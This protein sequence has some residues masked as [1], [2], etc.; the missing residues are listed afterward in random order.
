M[1]RWHIYHDPRDL[2]RHA[3]RAVL[4][5]AAEALSRRGR[6]DL[7]ISGGPALERLFGQFRDR[8]IGDA[9][10]HIWFTDERCLPDGHPEKFET[11]IRDMWL[12]HSRVPAE[13]IHGIGCSGAPEEAAGRYLESLQEVECFDLVLLAMGPD[14]Q[15]A[16]LFP[17]QGLAEFDEAPDVLAV[18]APQAP[19]ARITLSAGRLGATRQLVL[20]VSGEDK[21]RAVG[22]WRAG[23]GGLPVS[24]LRPGRG[25]DVFADEAAVP[26]F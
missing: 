17:G 14:G 3:Q 20:L 24:R 15:T 26:G 11:R 2:I 23:E 7:A 5:A 9:R 18:H 21:R 25:I 13:N 6:F 10:W 4:G 12:G 19:S 16:G 22:L 1:R 8:E